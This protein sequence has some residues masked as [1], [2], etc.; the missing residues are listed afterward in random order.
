MRSKNSSFS[1]VDVRNVCTTC[2][3]CAEIKPQF[4]KPGSQHCLKSTQPMERLSI[5][6]VGPKESS[7]RNKYFLTVVDEFSRFPSFFLVAI[8]PHETSGTVINCLRSSFSIIGCP[9]SIYHD[10]GRQFLSKE[11]KDFMSDH[12]VAQSRTLPYNPRGNGQC[13]RFNQSIWKDLLGATALNLPV[14]RWEDALSCQPQRTRLY[15]T[16]S[17]VSTDAPIAELHCRCDYGIRARYS[18]G[19]T[20]GIRKATLSSKKLI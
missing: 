1:T 5:D 10:R 13:E 20:L 19:I 2:K 17:F 3:I 15:T 9:E 12:G 11:E 16:D 6:F 18:V 8:R 7:T 14:A 4:F